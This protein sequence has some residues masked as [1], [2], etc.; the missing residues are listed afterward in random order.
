MIQAVE[1]RADKTIRDTAIK[2]CDERLIAITSRDLVAAEAHYHVSC[3]KSYT[4]CQKD[5]AVDDESEDEYAMAEKKALQQ[6]FDY[7]RMDI[8]IDP[9]LIPLNDLTKKLGSF[10]RDEGIEISK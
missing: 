8:F 2:K 9:R 7:I 5:V 10:L 3:Y 1:M 6:L 4:Y